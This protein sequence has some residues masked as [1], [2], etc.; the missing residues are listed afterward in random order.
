MGLDAYLFA[1]NE[2]ISEV[3]FSTPDDHEEVAYFRK[4]PDL[5]G[6]CEERYR[7]RNGADDTFNCVNLRLTL[8]DLLDLQD[9]TRHGKLP[10]TRGFFFGES[11]GD[12]YEALEA[13][14]VE[15]IDLT[16][17]GKNIFYHSWW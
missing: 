3:D 2:E 5:H 1:T 16:E 10:E 8:D 12:K 17:Q 9:A 7:E 4:H 14:L 11:D 15:C 6:W 13:A